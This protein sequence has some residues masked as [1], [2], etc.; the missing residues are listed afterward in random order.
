MCLLLSS[1]TNDLTEGEFIE[2]QNEFND[3]F[4]IVFDKLNDR[5]S[6]YLENEKTKRADVEVDTLLRKMESLLDD[7]KSSISKDDREPYQMMVETLENMKNAE[8]IIQNDLGKEDELIEY[9]NE[10]DKYN[11]SETMNLDLS[12]NIIEILESI[13]GITDDDIRAFMTE[14]SI[15][16][17]G[18]DIQYN[19]ANYVDKEFVLAG[20][21]ELDDYYNYGYDDDIESTYFCCNLEQENGGDRWYLYLHRDSCQDLFS[22]LKNGTVQAILACE[23]SSYR[24]EKNQGN[25]AGVNSLTYWNN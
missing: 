23:I 17:T 20:K 3:Y 12:N 19:M 21:L 7:N 25:M 8:D 10:L 2:V 5:G 1:C 6:F 24:Y 4:D 13:S 14:K 16:Y 11:I 9:Y 22:Q 15:K 18:D